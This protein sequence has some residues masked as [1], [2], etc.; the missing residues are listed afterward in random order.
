MFAL[1]VTV[2]AAKA[3]FVNTS[4]FCIAVLVVLLLSRPSQRETNEKGFVR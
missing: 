2:G 3:W 4:L 1:Y